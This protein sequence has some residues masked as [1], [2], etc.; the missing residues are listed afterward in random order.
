MINLHIHTN[1]SLDGKLNI[2]EVLN[3]CEENNLKYISITDHNTTEAYQEIT[4]N[5]YTG[6]IING[7][8]LDALIG[9]ILA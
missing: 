7:I 1:K 5:N 6:T 8:E 9:W 4:N 3:L 2:N